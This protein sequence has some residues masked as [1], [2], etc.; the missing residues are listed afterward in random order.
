V[1]LWVHNRLF[2]AY[3]EVKKKT[4]LVN[5]TSGEVKMEVIFSKRGEE[6]ILL[7]F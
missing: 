1:G 5:H 2:N 3:Y 6:F 4:I 7:V